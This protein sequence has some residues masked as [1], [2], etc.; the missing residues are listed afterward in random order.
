MDK[1]VTHRCSTAPLDLSITVAR[2]DTRETK[3]ECLDA[4]PVRVLLLCSWLFLLLLSGCILTFPQDW[5]RTAV[6]YSC[7]LVHRAE[8]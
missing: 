8:K 7:K 6:R 2:A 1:R 4:G 5:V 3:L